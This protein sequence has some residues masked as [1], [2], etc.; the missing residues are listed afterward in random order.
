[1]SFIGDST[2]V[3]CNSM[4]PCVHLVPIGSVS[5]YIMHFL[6]LCVQFLPPLIFLF[7]KERTLTEQLEEKV[8]AT[9]RD[10]DEARA[11]MAEMEQEMKALRANSLEPP[12]GKSSRT[13][14]TSSRGGGG[15]GKRISVPKGSGRKQS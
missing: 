10:L 2:T 12:S 11:K 9:E 5:D 3:T 7:R 6:T 1:M 14:R 15:G 13:S 8:Q 4:K